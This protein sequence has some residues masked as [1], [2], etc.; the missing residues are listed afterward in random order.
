MQHPW[1]PLCSQDPFAVHHLPYGILDGQVAVR[2]GEYAV[3]LINLKQKGYLYGLEI[4]DFKG[5]SLNPLLSHN[6]RELN[7]LRARLQE[8][9]ATPKPPQGWCENDLLSL[10]KHTPSCPLAPP[11]Y[12]D[13]YASSYHAKRVGEL[14]RDPDKAILPNWWHLPI[15]YHGRSSS[16]LSDP[17][18]ARP[19]GQRR[20]TEREEQPHFGPTQKLDFELELAAVV[21]GTS[22]PGQIVPLDQIQEHLFGVC[23]LNDWSARDIQGWEYVPLGP[24]LGKSFATSVSH[25]ITPWE[26]L[27]PFL[28]ERQ[29]KQKY[30]PLPYLQ[31][32]GF[33]H[34][35]ELELEAWIQPCGSSKMEKICTSNS[36][37]LY[38]SFAQQLTHLS[39]NGS[40]L[41]PGDLIASGTIS[42][43]QADSCGCLLESTQNGRN[44]LELQDCQRHFL[45]DGDTIELR[46]YGRHPQF[47]L[48]LAKVRTTLKQP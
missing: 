16:I 27:T 2:L 23:L 25:W 11:D 46:A 8:I 7:Q 36:R 15:G 5:D 10:S 35:L 17:K 38:W 24:F 22:S 43:P 47:P 34:H 37:Y 6:K 19:Q 20:N 18:I 44:P 41:S 21:C 4:Q 30:P 48:E 12:V 9:F 3:S 42:G 40:A 29:E 26:A 13:F 1:L 14:F 28:G 45:Q 31:D 33:K 32:H 39:S